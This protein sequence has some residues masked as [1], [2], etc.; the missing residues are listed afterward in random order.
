MAAALA[1]AL[2][3]GS[4][5]AQGS[6]PAPGQILISGVPASAPDIQKI[7]DGEYKKA[8]TAGTLDHV[9][10]QALAEHITTALKRAGYPQAHAYLADQ[11]AAYSF[12]AGAPPANA[13]AN[14]QAAASAVPA[15]SAANSAT[16]A[17]APSESGVVPPVKER[18]SSSAAA[19]KIAVRGFRVDGVGDH[20]DTGITFDS[21]QAM[22]DAQYKKLGGS[23]DQPAMLS[24]AQMQGVADAITDRYRKAGFIVAS[25]F[26]PAQTIG[27][28]Q[29]VQIQILEGRVGRIIVKGNKRYYADVIAAPAQ[30]LKGEP[31][32]KSTVDS[33]LL[34]VRDLPGVSV[35]STFQ[36]GRQTGDTDLVMVAREA[37]NPL[38]F[39]TGAD[40]YGTPLTGRYRALGGVTWNSPLGIGDSLSANADYAL[41][42]N[43][44]AYG[45]LAYTAPLVVVPGMSVNIGTTRSQ[46]QI[47]SDGFAALRVRGPTT[48]YVA[49]SD[50]KF[51]NGDDLKM[52]ASLHMIREQSRLS[53]Q[54]L[55]LSNE[56]FNLLEFGYAM[57]HTDKRFH[58]V[59]LLQVSVRKSLDDQS[60]DPDLVSPNHA[61][62][63][64]S[65]K[66]SYTRLQF[67]TQAQRLYFKFNGQWTPDA[68]APMEQFVIGGPDSVRAYPIAD[69]L[70]D[71]GYYTSLEYHV[72]A[73]GIGNMTSP[74]Y[75]RP[76]RE[77]LE[78]ETFLDYAR[79]F[80]AGADL[81]G[82]TPPVNFSGFGAGFIFRIPQFHHFEFHLDGSIPLGS[83][84]ATDRHGYHVYGRM[85]LT[86]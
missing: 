34:Y 74:F 54:G 38:T 22:A 66:V 48:T 7:I 23:T 63:F 2:G 85:G 45:S 24:F 35:A 65:L 19:Q 59:D 77:L 26:L 52:Q 39:T 64:A 44:N 1:L 61:H 33:A 55:Q 56:K 37:R 81:H 70:T 14:A 82:S 17:S 42:P 78:L 51:L 32:Q 69:G 68:L 62:D 12:G 76:W 31:L 60:H 73:P 29:K 40:N 71:R 30:Q 49:G 72:D 75:G 28:D 8:A 50:W 80:A 36:P 57:N 41:D 46:L 53:T 21:I 18:E 3:T 11:F 20:P 10:L 67:L 83:Q 5:W 58:G 13:G 16:L 9:Q 27:N 6:A 47:N 43:Q 79:G 4:L 84:Q 15:A 25:A 86:F